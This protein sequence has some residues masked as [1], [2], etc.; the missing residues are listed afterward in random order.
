MTIR[1]IKFQPFDYT[2]AGVYGSDEWVQNAKMKE[3][4]IQLFDQV[5]QEHEMKNKK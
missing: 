2:R 4:R 3:S 1:K 5:V